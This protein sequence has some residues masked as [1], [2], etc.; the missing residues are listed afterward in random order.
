MDAI[1]DE[2]LIIVWIRGDMRQQALL[3][4]GSEI[5]VCV[6]EEQLC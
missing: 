4:K 1:C 3:L 5:W 2:I 6:R